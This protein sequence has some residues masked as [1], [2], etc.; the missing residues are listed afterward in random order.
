LI[1]EHLI[2]MY[3]SEAEKF[4]K[5]M[6]EE[7]KRENKNQSSIPKNTEKET[8]RHSNPDKIN[9][10]NKDTTPSYMYSNPYLRSSNKEEDWAY[11]FRIIALGD[12]ST[13]HIEITTKSMSDKFTTDYSSIIAFDP[14]SRYE[15]IDGYKITFSVFVINTK[16]DISAMEKLVFRQNLGAIL[17][18]SFGSRISYDKLEDW[19][20]NIKAASPDVEFAIIGVRNDNDLQEIDQEEI[21]SKVEKLQGIFYE[22]SSEDNECLSKVFKLLGKKILQKRISN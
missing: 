1:L 4:R 12:P 17:F 6:L 20:E 21:N 2:T 22:M 7:Q 11:T 13:N 18:F 16:K 10:I 14:M 8:P 9:S 19:I 15:M 3:N 5:K